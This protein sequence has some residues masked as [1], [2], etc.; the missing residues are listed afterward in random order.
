[1]RLKLLEPVLVAFNDLTLDQGISK[2]DVYLK[3][4]CFASNLCLDLLGLLLKNFHE[5][6]DIVLID[7]WNWDLDLC[8]QIRRYSLND[9][10][11]V[12]FIEW[13]TNNLETFKIGQMLELE[14]L[15]L[16]IYVEKMSFLNFI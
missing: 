10:Y 6:I 8:Q 14:T 4:E 16:M 7:L 1:M 13:S 12:L 5:L 15:P 11:E 3:V 9:S 2:R